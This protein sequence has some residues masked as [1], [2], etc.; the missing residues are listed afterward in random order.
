MPGTVSLLN[1]K[2]GLEMKKILCTVTLMSAALAAQAAVEA[3]AYADSGDPPSDSRTVRDEVRAVASATDGG[4]SSFAEADLV[5]G[6]LKASATSTARQSGAQAIIRERFTFSEGASGIAYLDWRFHGVITKSDTPASNI[7]M[8]L[9]ILDFSISDGLNPAT[10]DA[11][12]LFELGCDGIFNYGYGQCVGGT[13]VESTGSIEIPI[14][15]RVFNIQIA[16]SIY[17]QQFDSAN[18]ANTALMYLRLPEG[19]SI[20]SESGAFLSLAQPITP[21]PEPAAAVLFLAGLVPLA[22]RMR[23]HT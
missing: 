8:S 16:L 22:R 21:V 11:R 10:R 9:G 15:S 19:V 6:V 18:F 4:A 14:S 12:A 3:L 17:A 5:R 7:T 20:S 1:D 23:R 13:F 2:G